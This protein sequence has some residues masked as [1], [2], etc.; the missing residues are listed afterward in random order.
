MNRKGLAAKL[1][2]LNHITH[3]I[4]LFIAQASILAM[5]AIVTLTVISVSYTHLDVYKRQPANRYSS[6]TEMTNSGTHTPMVA[7][8]MDIP[9]NKLPRLTAEVTP[10]S[11]PVSYTHLDVYK[12]QCVCRWCCCI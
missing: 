7:I 11:T 12:R 8:T 1:V 9:S 4:V 5:V 6:R 2:K 10:S 3:K